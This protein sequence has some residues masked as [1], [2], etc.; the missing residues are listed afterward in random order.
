MIF[1]LKMMN[2]ALTMMK[3]AL[4]M[5]IIAFEMLIFVLLP[6]HRRMSCTC[7]EWPARR[8]RG[9]RPCLLKMMNVLVGM[10]KFV[11]KSDESCIKSDE[12]CCQK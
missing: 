5:M 4:K 3:F 12:I 2:F 7:M 8:A 1:V 10:M 11:S 6:G 9:H